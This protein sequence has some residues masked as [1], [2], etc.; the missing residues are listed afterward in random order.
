MI[1]TGA[2]YDGYA[3]DIS[4]TFVKGNISKRKNDI[5]TAVKRVQSEAIQA[6]K[7][8]RSWDEHERVMRD[9]MNTT[10]K[11]LG[12]IPE[13]CTKGEEEVFSRKYF[14]HRMSHFLGLDVHDTGERSDILQSGMVITC[15]PGIYIKDEGIG[16]RIEDDIL[17]TEN[18]GE[19]LSGNIFK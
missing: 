6:I 19:V 9:I 15:E 7:P 10:L 12:L 17:I 8:G 14:P 2:E 11:Q 3:A 18:G 1:D 5:Y 13:T 4:R 16:V